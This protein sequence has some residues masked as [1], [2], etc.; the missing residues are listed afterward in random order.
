MQETTTRPRRTPGAGSLYETDGGLWRGAYVVEDPL[1]RRRMRR[2]VSGHSKA[3]ANRRLRDAIA[4][5]HRDAEAAA[6]PTLAWWA[7]RWLDTVAH[8][9]RPATW[10]G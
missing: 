4:D 2:Y 7:A 3:E 5:S 8:R 9:I 10:S 1:T 6:S